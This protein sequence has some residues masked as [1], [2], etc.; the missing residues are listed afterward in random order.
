MLRST[1]NPPRTFKSFWEGSSSN[2]SANRSRP[3]SA[4]GHTTC[5]SQVQPQAQGQA[6]TGQAQAQTQAHAQAQGQG[7]AHVQ[8]AQGHIV[9]KAHPQSPLALAGGTGTGT[10]TGTAGANGVPGPGSST[11]PTGV[12]RP[13]PSPSP[14]PSHSSVHLQPRSRPLSDSTH[15]QTSQSPS[16]SGLSLARA[17]SN[18]GS[19]LAS[20]GSMA[21]PSDNNFSGYRPSCTPFQLPAAASSTTHTQTAL[22]NTNTTTNT[23][24]AT[25]TTTTASIPS[26]TTITYDSSSSSSVGSAA[27]PANTTTSSSSSSFSKHPSSSSSKPC[28]R[29]SPSPSSACTSPQPVT[30]DCWPL[31]IPAH[32][33]ATADATYNALDNA[34]PRPVGIRD[35]SPF[36]KN[37]VAPVG[38]ELRVLDA[39]GDIDIDDYPDFHVTD[40][41][42]LFDQHHNP[43]L[44]K[45]HAPASAQRD[46]DE[47]MTTGPFDSA[48]GRS[49]QD[50]FVGTKPISMNISNQARDQANRPRR[51]SLAGSYMGG[52]LMGGMSWGGLSVGSFIRDE[53]VALICFCTFVSSFLFS[54]LSVSQ[55]V[56]YLALT[57]Q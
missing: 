20:K 14:S 39:D 56:P 22:N 27:V 16:P 4:E 50:S 6:P 30:P 19:A 49:R 13:A 47:V 8:Q 38:G 11:G 17:S 7:A 25:A 2:T 18:L 46:D 53:Y 48:M 52:S 43:D 44:P 1:Q 45:H 23:T 57:C 9:K 21:S 12:Q 34:K 15:A 29:R 32:P 41:G 26:P 33:N 51:E 10:G 55:P 24:T 5:G 40:P 3:S 37:P 54:F 31:D 42:P 35:P 28:T 36:A